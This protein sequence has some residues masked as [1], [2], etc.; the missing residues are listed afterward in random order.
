MVAQRRAS[1][2]PQLER[3]R[4]DAGLIDTLGIGTV[5]QVCTDQAFV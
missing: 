2:R 4:Y 1:L 3:T 5:L